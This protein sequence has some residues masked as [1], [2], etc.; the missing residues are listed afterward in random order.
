MRR[1]RALSAIAGT[2]IALALSACSGDAAE[3]T[4]GSP[5]SD[6]TGAVSAPPSPG[7]LPPGLAECYAEKG[8]EITSPEEIHSAPQDVV[9]ACFQSLHQGGGAP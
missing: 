4:T 8:Y 7:A 3:T 9:N 6:D 2:L 5:A 1:L